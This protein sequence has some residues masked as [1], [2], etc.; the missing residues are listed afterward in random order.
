MN[1]IGKHLFIKQV[2]WIGISFGIG[3]GVSG[4]F[5]FQFSIVVVIGSFLLLNFYLR[6][7]MITRYDVVRGA[8]HGGMYSQT[9]VDGGSLRCYCMSWGAR[10]SKLHALSV[11]QK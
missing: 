7:E 4:L 3:V 10:H 11:V 8:I 1:S 6:R 2:V 5:P 9:A